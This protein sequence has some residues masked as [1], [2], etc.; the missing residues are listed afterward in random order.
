[1]IKVV[2][3][4]ASGFIGRALCRFLLQQGVVVYAIVRNRHSM[5][6]FAYVDNLEIIDL[7][8]DQY[9]KIA[10]IIL[11]K[12]IDVFYHLAWEGTSGVALADYHMQL[13]NVQYSCNAIMAAV[14]L[15]CKKFIFTGTVN[16]LE[17][18]KQIN[19]DYC[20]PRLACI[21]GTAKLA[22]EMM[23]KTLAYNHNIGFNTAILSSVF[24]PGDNSVTIQNVLLKKLIVGEKLKL[25][26]GDF[27]YDWIYIDDA[28]EMLRG[29]GERSKNFRRYYIGH[30]TLRT[31]KEIVVEVRNIVNPEMELVF[32]EIKE[33]SIIDFSQIDVNAV[34]ED[35]GILPN[36][37]FKESVKKTVKWIKKLSSRKI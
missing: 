20:I 15:K 27:L 25:V 8:L 3:T 26:S 5:S 16:E 34:Y 32:G 17:V 30:P 33:S 13:N 29:I 6:E 12:D 7:S 22:C 2:I 36:S 31:F 9:N 14:E 35:T 10:S 23:C 18:V 21:Y 1:M 37:D 11:D 28:V 4:G 24:G 19:M